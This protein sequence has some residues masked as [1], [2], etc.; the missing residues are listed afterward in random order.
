MYKYQTEHISFSVAGVKWSR[1][2]KLSVW[3]EPLQYNKVKYCRN[4]NQTLNSHSDNLKFDNTEKLL[5]INL[6]MV[7]RKQIGL[8][9][10]QSQFQ[11]KL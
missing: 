5:N 11:K 8:C 7:M 10:V 9:F 6:V 1:K 3:R 4:S 2:G